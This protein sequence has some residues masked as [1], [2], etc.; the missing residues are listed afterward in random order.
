LLLALAL[1]LLL[2]GAGLF[3]LVQSHA[4]TS[5]PYPPNY[6][7]LSLNDLLRDNSGGYGWPVGTSVKNGKCQFAQGAYHVSTIKTGGFYYCVEGET[8]FNNF[9]YEARMT[10]VQGDDGGLIFRAN[11]DKSQFYYFDVG[12]D[13]SYALYLYLDASGSHAQR[14]TAGRAAA[15][16]TGLNQPNLLAVVV[17]DNKLMLYVNHQYIASVNDSK[18]G[19]GQIGFAAASN[20][21]PTEVAFSDAKVW[22]L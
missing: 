5:I 12:P 17:Q 4:T 7:S 1:V 16:Y 19:S 22:T 2:V 14:L 10:I 15:I 20:T 21:D 8:T 3:S 6:G 13:G 18:Y 11:G 9:V